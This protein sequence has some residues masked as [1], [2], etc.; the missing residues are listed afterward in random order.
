MS[1]ADT[2][3]LLCELDYA[4]IYKEGSRTVG[5]IFSIWASQFK[6]DLD[7]T[8]AKYASRIDEEMVSLI[9]LIST[10]QW[11][12]FQRA[13]RRRYENS[14]HRP[15]MRIQGVEKQEA[16]MCSDGKMRK[17][18]D[19]MAKDYGLKLSQLENML[20]VEFERLRT[21]NIGSDEPLL[22]LMRAWW[23]YPM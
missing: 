12:D 20:K 5:E 22:L 7:S 8:V 16:R 3:G 1:E 2:F 15:E 14:I 11:L 23:F 9:S 13:Q 6:E 4:D 19:A 18:Y 21:R 17:Y 10:H